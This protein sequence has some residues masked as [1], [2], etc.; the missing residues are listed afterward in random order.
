MTLFVDGCV[1]HAPILKNNSYK[2]LQSIEKPVFFYPQE[3]EIFVGRK[4]D[5]VL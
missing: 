3:P 1:Q 5:R 2:S 4:E